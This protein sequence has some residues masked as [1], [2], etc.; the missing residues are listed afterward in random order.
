[1][2]KRLIIIFILTF[3]CPL[4]VLAAGGKKEGVIEEYYD[5]GV[6]K[7]VISVKQG[8]TYI[9]EFSKKGSLIRKATYADDKLL[10]E[11]IY[12]ESGRRVRD[13]IYKSYYNNGTIKAEQRFERGKRNG[14]TKVYDQNG[15]L[16]QTIDYK[17]GKVVRVKHIGKEVPKKPFTYL[18]VV[19]F[20][21]IVFWILFAKFM[22]LD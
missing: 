15:K 10:K 18:I 6:L 1:M 4:L 17:D 11:Y 20:V 14:I 22:V 13:G 7:H 5:S 8:R 21:C 19:F 16:A 12:D 2:K 9:E 3:A